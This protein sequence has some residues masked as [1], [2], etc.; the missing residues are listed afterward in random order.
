MKTWLRRIGLGV[1]ALLLAGLGAGAV[2][3]Q[4][5]RSR[6]ARAFPPPGRMVDIGGRRIQIDCRGAGSPVVVFEAND[7][8]GSLSWASVQKEVARTTRTCSYSRAGFMWSDP[9]S[10]PRDDR[11]LASDLRAVLE[12]AGEPA[13]FVLVGHSLGGLYVVNYTHYFGADVAGLVLVDPAHPDMVR[14]YKAITHRDLPLMP[15]LMRLLSE[16]PWTAL[17]RMLI[18]P[19]ANATWEAGAMAAYASTSLAAYGKE[20]PGFAT[21]LANARAAHALGKRPLIVL[22]AMAPASAAARQETQMSAAQDR[23][24]RMV[25]KAMH[26]DIATWSAS[27]RHFLVPDSGHRIQTERPDLVIRAVGS[28]VEAVRSGAAVPRW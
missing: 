12:K 10:G 15:P 26:D 25:W 23:S 17:T 16:T 20:T 19:S 18:S 6:A 2:A 9:A 8:F 14:H 5:G 1:I 21:T 7:L 3:E 4:L 28:V 22:S 11:A 24:Y 13:P 27:G